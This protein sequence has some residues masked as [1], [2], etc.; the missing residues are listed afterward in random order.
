MSLA[1]TVAWTP[2]R[3]I[4]PDIGA[5]SLVPLKNLSA[6]LLLCVVVV[7]RD[8]A[9]P[10][11]VI[12]SSVHKVRRDFQVGAELQRQAGRRTF[13]PRRPLQIGPEQGLALAQRV[14]LEGG[15][16]GTKLSFIKSG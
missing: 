2:Y 13:R 6:R 8:A 11:R 7:D 1:G 16:E 3:V 12:L 5:A 4:A 15:R 14:I 9:Q 10:R